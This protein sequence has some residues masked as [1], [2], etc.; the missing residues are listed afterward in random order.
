[1]THLRPQSAPPT[2]CLLAA[3]PPARRNV[4][5]T[6]EDVAAAL[7]GRMASCDRVA[8]TATRR[9]ARVCLP[10]QLL[11]FLA[12]VLTLPLQATPTLPIPTV[13]PTNLTATTPT[14]ITATCQPTT[15]AGDP[16]LLPN[17][18]NLIRRSNT[19]A[20]V[21]VL[22]TMHDDGLNGDATAD[23]GIYTL[24]FTTTEPTP[25]T[26]QLECAAA[27]RNTVRRVRSSTPATVSVYL[28]PTL[29]SFTP[30]SGPTGTAITLT[31]TNLAS[32]IALSMPGTSGTPAALTIQSA[33]ATSIT[34][35]I[36]TG[37]ATGPIT[38][39][40]PA[41]A[42]A[43]TTT[44]FTLPP[45]ITSFSPTSGATG[46]VVTIIGT[47]L[48]PGVTL[49]MPSTGTSPVALTIQSATATSLTA[50]I[51][52]TAATGPIT[53]TNS[54]SAT[55]TSTT[56]FTV[57]LPPTITSFTPTSGPTGTV[58]TI[59]GTNLGSGITLSMP[60]TGSSPVA[61]T[62]Q[63]AT[64]TTLTAVIPATAVTGPITATNSL[65]ATATST[66]SFTISSA[67]APTLTSFSPSSGTA[68]TIVALSGT[69]LVSGIQLTMPGVNGS[70]V[71]LPLQGMT[72]TS[73]SVVIP[74]GTVTGPITAT[75]TN[76]TATTA[77]PFT[78]NPPC[79]F[80]LSISPASTTL[81]QGQTIAYSVQLN[82]SNGFNLLAP[83]S[84]S[85]L[86]SG[87]TAS[88]KPASITTGQTSV[89]TLTASA[90][91]AVATSSV[92]VSATVTV[93]GVDQSQSATASLSV[94]APTTSFVGRTVVADAL[95][96]PLAGVTVSTLGQNGSG[97]STGCVNHTTVSDSAGNFQLTNLPA[98][99]TGPQLMSFDGGTATSPTGK[100]DGVHLVFT[101]TSGQVTPSPVFV[102][103]PRIDTAEVFYVQ[104]NSSTNQTHSFTSIPGL[105][106]TV[107]AGTTLTLPDGT[108]PNPFPVSVVPVLP[109]RLPDQ[110][111]VVPTM[112]GAF[113]SSFQ[114]TG[115][116]ASQPVAVTYPNTL[117]TAPGTDMPLMVLD[118]IHGSFT[119]VGTGKVSADGTVIVPDPDPAHPGH[120]YG[121]IDFDW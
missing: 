111:P 10:P 88:F 103:L 34:A 61:L 56:S 70:P 113:Y 15:T 1:M 27:Y 23:D 92:T 38:A 17:G 101:L 21:S 55:A 25:G 45:T 110:K 79:T 69:N 68:G 58:V 48:S 47:N 7:W 99:C 37:A 83:L 94:V 63:S 115:T 32:S 89:L 41:G 22:G 71:S 116:H 112:V 26:F 107:Y 85:G 81:I 33:T 67:S 86:P 36:P 52:T 20:P 31:G 40:N 78:V 62:I 29:T 106:V 97:S 42:T 98:Q 18:L 100:Y 65:A 117:N 95:Q 46:T 72:A 16:T 6:I 53:A 64:A 3:L 80:S 84:V 119:P 66:A 93:Q 60:S 13:T 91:Q 73:A 114:P 59:T 77:T 30:Q 8:D 51:P 109:D 54:A 96:T 104:Q 35:L 74:V 49:A 87:V 4:W 50:V 108:R 14:Q 43:T 12:L 11:L 24:R 118:A 39:T 28:P 121:I 102:H 82:S 9:E 2:H 57:T 76:G 5:G 105:S 120:A 75:T 44:S 90:T 19:G